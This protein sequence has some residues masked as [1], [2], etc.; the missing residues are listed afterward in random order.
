MDRLTHEGYID[1]VFLLKLIRQGDKQ[2]FKYLFDLYFV[3]L[4]RFVRIYIG[5][6]QVAEE[7]TLD[8]FVA[9]WER[10][11]NIEIKI[12]WK[13]YLFQSAKNRSLNYLRDHERF[14]SI[15]DW[16]LHDRAE[17]DNTVE[18]KELELLIQEAICALPGRVQEIFKKSRMEYLTNK[19]IS[20]ELN[21]SVKNVEAH[22]TKAIKL[23]KKYLGDSYT[24]FW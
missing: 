16:S 7:I 4:C 21:I 17:V 1:D 8:L 12:S 14:V 19:E 11:E 13:S 24:Y 2:A 10:K 23:I 9:I 3:P 18:I 20:E 5:E 22:I 6:K 15:S